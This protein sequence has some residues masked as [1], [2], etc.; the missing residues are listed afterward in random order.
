MSFDSQAMERAR[1]GLSHD[2]PI[3]LRW[4]LDKASKRLGTYGVKV[5]R[6]LASGHVDTG[7]TVN[8]ITYAVDIKRD[9]RGGWR[10]HLRVFVDAKSR[11][12]AIKA[13]VL[14]FGRGHGRA[15]GR[16][17]GHLPPRSYLRPS[18]ELVARRARGA[19]AKAMRE[20][21]RALAQN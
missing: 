11:L 3:R 20:A 10:Y 14:E 1:R 18:R 17:R 19:F 8:A 13:F 5:A 16:A 15:G 7:E 12:A 2:I 4:N 9:S 21:A 6:T